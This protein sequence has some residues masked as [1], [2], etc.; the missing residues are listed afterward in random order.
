[1]ISKLFPEK[2][3]DVTST[4][5][6]NSVVNLQSQLIAKREVAIASLVNGMTQLYPEQE[7]RLVF[8]PNLYFP[9]MIG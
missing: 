3:T 6:W 4:L 9:S 8:F 7:P 5:V 2:P 1:M